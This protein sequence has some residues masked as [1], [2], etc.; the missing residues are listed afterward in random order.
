MDVEVTA[1][2]GN[3]FVALCLVSYTYMQSVPF[4][5]NHR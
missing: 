5:L 4:T 3:E 1:V 2:V